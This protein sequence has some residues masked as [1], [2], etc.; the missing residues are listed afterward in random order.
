MKKHKQNSVK[1]RWRE[2]ME[3]NIVELT[4][5]NMVGKAD[6]SPDVNRLDSVN[7]QQTSPRQDLRDLSPAKTVIIPKTSLMIRGMVKDKNKLPN[8]FLKKVN[9]QKDSHR[10]QSPNRIESPNEIQNPKIEEG[11]STVTFYNDSVSNAKSIAIESLTKG[12]SVPLSIVNNSPLPL[13][14][15]VTLQSK[16]SQTDLS[17]ILSAQKSSSNKSNI[18]TEHKRS[19]S[20]GITPNISVVEP[21]K[22]ENKVQ[23]IGLAAIEPFRSSLAQNEIKSPATSQAGDSVRLILERVGFNKLLIDTSSTSST[24][25]PLQFY[26]TSKG[27]KSSLKDEVKVL[28]SEESSPLL[29]PHLKTSYRSPRMIPNIKTRMSTKSQS[30]SL[31]PFDSMIPNQRA[32]VVDKSSIPDSKKQETDPVGVFSKKKCSVTTLEL[33]IV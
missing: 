14:K 8:K 25:V 2:N 5:A 18:L 33:S 23:K 30:I 4:E 3:N 11:A 32:E 19:A 17:G 16:Q 6:L 22:G 15:S 1:A 9:R 28:K 24:H 29:S 12:V 7:Q 20:L 31:L 13:L 26:I 10:S 27:F 21:T